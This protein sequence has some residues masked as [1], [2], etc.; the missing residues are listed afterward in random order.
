[1][2]RQTGLIK[3]KGNIGGISFYKS[4]GEDLARTASG[5]SKQRILSDPDFQ[6]TRE[7]NSEF[8]GSA[9]MAKALRL[10]LISAIQNKGDSLLP[11]RLTR[12]F[13]EVN[14]KGTGA[15]GKRSIPLSENKTMLEGFDFNSHLSFS[16][17]FN[18]PY[19]V[20]LQGS[21]T[22]ASIIIPNFMPADYIQAPQGAEYFRLVTAIGAV[23]DHVFNNDSGHYEPVDPSLNTLGS[24]VYSEVTQIATT[25]PA[26]FTLVPTLPGDP[27]PTMTAT[28]S[29]VLCLG[30]DFFL[31]VGTINYILSQ[32]NCL[33]VIK[34]F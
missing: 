9:H 4:G 14:A 30:I 10:S 5:P 29:V 22:G 26:T 15:R 8:G 17:V 31:R 1:M 12:I 23:S 25:T 24:V 27:A 6:R 33:K 13:K 20:I 32:G 2:S 7:N 3:L 19:D 34:V 21:R 16:S 11:S 28:T 18:A